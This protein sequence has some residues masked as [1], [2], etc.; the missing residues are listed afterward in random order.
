MRI[1]WLRADEA[2]GLPCPP[3][4]SWAA[5]SKR[6][7][8]SHTKAWLTQGTH[9]RCRADGRT[10]L[11]GIKRTLNEIWASPATVAGALLWLQ[12]AVSEVSVSPDPIG[13]RDRGNAVSFFVAATLLF[14]GCINTWG[15]RM[16][17]GRSSASDR[18][19]RPPTAWPCATGSGR[20]TGPDF[21]YGSARASSH[22][23]GRG[24]EVFSGALSIPRPP[25]RRGCV[26]RK[27]L[28]GG[29][30][31]KGNRVGVRVAGRRHK[32]PVVPGK[33]TEEA[34]PSRP[35]ADPKGTSSS[36]T[37]WPPPTPSSWGG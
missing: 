34:G 10:V 11:R 27:R 25:A 20:D 19:A 36:S 30:H 22:R 29:L 5:L 2:E 6:A 17:R 15:R 37:S 32:T 31:E 4:V 21:L 16:I 14:C 23:G 12:P 7:S 35:T 1:L 26:G 8:T 18:R 28:R 9:K 33:T 3:K 24:P 13:L